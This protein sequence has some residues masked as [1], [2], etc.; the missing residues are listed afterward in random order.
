MLTHMTCLHS[1]SFFRLCFACDAMC[2]GQG[3]SGGRNSGQSMMMDALRRI[4]EKK[5]A[6]AASGGVSRAAG[7]AAAYVAP[8]A[9][10]YTDNTNTPSYGGNQQPGLCFDFQKGMCRRGASCRFAH[11]YE[12]RNRAANQPYAGNDITAEEIEERLKYT[13]GDDVEEGMTLD[14]LKRKAEM[15]RTEER[16]RQLTAMSKRKH[17][18]GD[19]IP[20]EDLERFLEKVGCALSLLLDRAL[21]LCSVLQA[22]GCVWLPYCFSNNVSRSVSS[23]C[24]SPLS[25]LC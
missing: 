17:H 25:G 2:P 23:A 13:T 16:A 5:L 7:N 24:P 9:V 8:H 21:V 19:Y 12:E 14:Q 4:Q 22:A 15:A 11:V 20:E 6:L 3:T 18:I 10:G 1:G